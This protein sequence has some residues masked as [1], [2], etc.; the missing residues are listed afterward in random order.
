MQRE[1]QGLAEQERELWAAWD[2]SKTSATKEHSKV[3]TS[4]AG[5]GAQ[6]GQSAERSKTTEDQ[7][8]DSSY[9]RLILDIRDKRAKLL[10][11]DKPLRTEL[12][13][14]DG[15]PIRFESEYDIDHFAQLLV[16]QL[17]EGKAD[18]GS[19][20]PGSG[21]PAGIRETLPQGV[22]TEQGAQ[23]RSEAAPGDS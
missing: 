15:G 13:G 16:D 14:P 18:R 11:L 17:A 1:L 10:G 4:P 3:K 20:I 19:G 22:D 12:S 23:V 21:E 5:T 7:C 2:K 9:Q 6:G 8:G